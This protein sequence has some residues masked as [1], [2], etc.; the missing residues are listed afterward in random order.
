MNAIDKAISYFSPSAGV[1]RISARKALA[2]YEA[3][4][5]SRNRNF[6]RGRRTQN[7]LVQKSAEAL[8]DQVRHLT[9]NHDMARG[10]LRTMVNNVVGPNGIAVEPQ[11]RLMDGRIHKELSSHLRELYKDWC[12]RP[13][14]THRFTYSKLQRAAAKSWLRDGEVFGQAIIGNRPDLDHGTAA[15]FS[16]EMFEA[17]MVPLNLND[18]A[19]RIMQGIE[20]NAWGRPTGLHV[21]KSD[22]WSAAQISSTD[23]K[24]IPWSRVIHLA[25]LD[26]IGQLRGVTEFASVITRLEDIKDY[27][28]SERVAAKIAAMMTAYVKK[29]NAEAY[30]SE[31][32]TDEDRELNF[33]PGMIIDD[34]LPGEEIGMVDSSKR[35][36]P[37]LI[38]FRQGQLRAVAAGVGS[39]YSSTSKDYN[40]T[41][42]AQRQELVEQWVHYAV[43]A[44]DFVANLVQ[45]NWKTFVQAA[46]LSGQVTVPGD[47]KPGTLDDAL[48]VAQA[49][50]WIDPL[51]E[52]LG[53]EA[54]VKA[55]FESEVAVIRRRGGNP[56]E[57]LEQIDA[58]REECRDRGIVFSSNEAALEAATVAASGGDSE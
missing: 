20:R 16:L 41:Y 30:D 4:T 9:R 22:P 34:L 39:S 36:N 49:M 43:L 57:V 45:P 18:P 2:Y 17:D 5:P 8:R 24:R 50:P 48:F 32:T 7:Q 42:S 27:E 19:K 1:R 3:A 56:M 25:S 46:V 31:I 37:N 11:P 38:T 55:G 40:G 35:P 14:V 15:P 28:E 58:W 54:L 53:S 47:L 29:G 13:E 6:Y 23:T 12:L 26:S 33:D 21:F 10:V 44:D 51:K 52:A